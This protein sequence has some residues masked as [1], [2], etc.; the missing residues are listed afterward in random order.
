[1]ITHDQSHTGSL[2]LDIKEKNWREERMC[3]GMPFNIRL[4]LSGKAK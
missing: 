1:M 3:T 2:E 4:L